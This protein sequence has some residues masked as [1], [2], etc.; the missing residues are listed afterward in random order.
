MKASKVWMRG[1]EGKGETPR[2]EEERFYHLESQ[3]RSER[4]SQKL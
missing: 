1:G 4:F 2:P 3:T